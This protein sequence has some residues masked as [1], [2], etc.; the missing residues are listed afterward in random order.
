MNAKAVGDHSS[1]LNTLKK[2]VGDHSD[3]KTVQRLLMIT[4]T[5]GQ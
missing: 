3:L 5:L 1:D 2:A 4:V